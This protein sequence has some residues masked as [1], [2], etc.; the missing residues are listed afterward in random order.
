MNNVTQAVPQ[1][2]PKSVKKVLEKDI[3]REICKWLESEGYFF[4]RSNNVPVFERSG[5]KGRFRALPKYTPRGLPDIMM[6]TYGNFIGIEVKKPGFWK[7]TPEQKLMGQMI[8][9]NGGYYYL[10]TSLA[11][12]VDILAMVEQNKK[13]LDDVT[14]EFNNEDIEDH[15]A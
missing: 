6:I 12:V 15:I 4:W 14:P 10:V 3:Q 2:R 5:G 1:R 7:N 9:Q 13:D 8:K 11:E